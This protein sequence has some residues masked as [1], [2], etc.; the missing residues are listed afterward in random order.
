MEITK[1]RKTAYQLLSQA[2]LSTYAQ[3]VANNCV[4]GTF[5]SVRAE[6]NAVRAASEAFATAL[7]AARSKDTVKVGIKNEK[8]TELINALNTLVNAVE[9]MPEFSTVILLEA[10]FS[11]YKRRSN[12]TGDLENPSIVRAESTGK[13]GELKIEVEDTNGEAFKQFCFEYSTDQ[14]R[15]WHNGRYS[16]RRSFV[17]NNLPASSDVQLRCRVTGT[18]DR[19]S[20]WSAVYVAAV[21]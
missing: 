18:R 1:I 12:S 7:A 8:Q 16:G 9:A 20:D 11:P 17:W 10:G 3:N 2:E 13:R 6:V 4:S 14:G 19:I 21:L 5:E 15:V